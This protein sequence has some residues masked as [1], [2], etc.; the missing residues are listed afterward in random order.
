VLAERAARGFKLEHC[1]ELGS[2]SQDIPWLE[3]DVVH[4]TEVRLGAAGQQMSAL[5]G[6]AWRLGAIVSRIARALAWRATVSRGRYVTQHYV[7]TLPAHTMGSDRG[8]GRAV[9]TVRAKQLW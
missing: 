4:A 1:G 8:F 3:H 9:G 2:L 6:F 5:P 7:F